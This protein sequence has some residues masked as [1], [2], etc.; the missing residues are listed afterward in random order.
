MIYVCDHAHL[1][2]HGRPLESLRRIDH[3]AI[4]DI[5][6]KKTAPSS[7]GSKLLGLIWSSDDTAHHDDVRDQERWEQRAMDTIATCGITEMFART[8]YYKPHVLHQLLRALFLV[9]AHG[10]HANN[11]SIE[12][13]SGRIM[14]EEAAVFCLERV[15]DIVEKNQVCDMCMCLRDCAFNR[16]MCMDVSNAILAVRC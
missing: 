10:T 5:F 8:K 4:H 16:G 9:S 15:A 2:S 11:T 14:N 13:Y 12:V 3:A 6:N 7:I 1:I